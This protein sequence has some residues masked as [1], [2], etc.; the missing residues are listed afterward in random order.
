MPASQ[1]KSTTS[2]TDPRTVKQSPVPLP[3]PEDFRQHL[4]LLAVS[5]VRSCLN[6]SCAK[7]WSSALAL[8]GEKL[9]PPAEAIVTASCKSWNSVALTQFW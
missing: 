3:E 1:K 5:A 8:R 9:P 7:N 2:N 6:K 4:R